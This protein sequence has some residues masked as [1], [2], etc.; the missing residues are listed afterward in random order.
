MYIFNHFPGG[1]HLHPSQKNR[2]AGMQRGAAVVPWS[3]AHRGKSYGNWGFLN[4]KN[5]EKS[6][7]YIGIYR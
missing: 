1:V 4:G 7:V 6:S 3:W 5:V 2:V